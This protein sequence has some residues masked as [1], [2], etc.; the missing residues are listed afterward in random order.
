MTSTDSAF[1]RA[2]NTRRATHIDRSGPG[3]GNIPP[4]VSMSETVI[5]S[6]H[7]NFSEIVVPPINFQTNPAHRQVTG[8]TTDV[9]ASPRT[10]GAKPG[11][12][13]PTAG[14]APV[15]PK[16]K[17]F[18]IGPVGSDRVH[19]RLDTQPTA[20]APHIK[21]SGANLRSGTEYQVNET[22]NAA[23]SAPTPHTAHAADMQQSSSNPKGTFHR[24]DS[25][26]EAELRGPHSLAHFHCNWEVDAFQWPEICHRLQGE[27][28][29]GLSGL[30]RSVL[31][32]AWRGRHVFALTSFSRGEGI[33]TVTLCLAKL[34]A[35]FDVKVAIVDGNVPNPRIV[36]ELGVATEFGWSDLAQNIPLAEIAIKS[37][38]DNLVVVPL[39]PGHNP[40]ECGTLQEQATA[41]IAQLADAFELVLIDAGPMFHAAHLWLAPPTLATIHGGVVVRNMQLTAAEQ[42]DDVCWRLQQANI[43]DVLVVE[44]F[45]QSNRDSAHV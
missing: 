37:L 4:G 7:A 2:F 20:E 15:Q 21:I 39:R 10:P 33:T 13:A 22:V 18:T 31:H 8:N 28:V 44:N 9:L 5:P 14:S 32:R 35:M 12:G 43:R 1:I 11:L 25:A 29:S 26:A 23:L 45:Q 3:Y 41:T 30:L 27:S 34:A 40:R 42:M 36:D 19:L 24:Y 38:E 16:T 6:P 17:T